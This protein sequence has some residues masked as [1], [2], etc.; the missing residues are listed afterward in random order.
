MITA[1]RIQQLWAEDPDNLARSFARTLRDFGYT[2]TPDWVKEQIIKS[3]SGGKLVG[4]P[5]MFIEHWLKEG[6]D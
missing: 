2:L 3:Q 1:K 5:G 6:M 4:G